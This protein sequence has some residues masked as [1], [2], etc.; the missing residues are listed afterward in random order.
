MT[1][2]VPIPA[3]EREEM[4]AQAEEAIRRRYHGFP[5]V[6]AEALLRM[7]DAYE[8]MLKER[9]AEDGARSND[10]A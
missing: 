5:T 10:S 1:A 4:R 3:A 8:E 7:L 2:S 9:E 6:L